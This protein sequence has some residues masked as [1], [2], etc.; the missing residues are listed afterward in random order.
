MNFSRKINSWFGL[1]MATAMVYVGL[2]L[3]AEVIGITDGWL[4]SIAVETTIVGH[5]STEVVCGT[6]E[7]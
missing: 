3:L 7:G 2:R 5:I 1:I 4:F 6:G